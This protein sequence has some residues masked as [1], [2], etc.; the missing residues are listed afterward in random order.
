PATATGPGPHFITYPSAGNRSVRLTVTQGGCS[1]T[2]TNIYTVEDCVNTQCG[3]ISVTVKKE[4]DCTQANG[5]LSVDVCNGC[6]TAFPITV[7]YK[8]ADNDFT[9]G[10]FASEP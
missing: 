7:H 5:E 8:F 1:K 9:A 6:G 4:A 10:P 3:L 2:T